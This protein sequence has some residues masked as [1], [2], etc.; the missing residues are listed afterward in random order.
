MGVN[1]VLGIALVQIIGF[2]GIAAATAFASWLNVGQMV[3]TRRKRG[4]W[5]P[6][7]VAA[8]KL[9]RKRLGSGPGDHRMVEVGGR[10]DRHRGAFE[11]TTGRME[12]KAKKWGQRN[13]ALPPVFWFP[14]T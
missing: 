9:V 11:L 7:P 10:I 13:G 14:L 8:G 5:T 6:S 12:P 3:W 4:D 1:I 2:V